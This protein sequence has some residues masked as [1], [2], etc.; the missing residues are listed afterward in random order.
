MLKFGFED[1]GMTTTGSVAGMT[2]TTTNQVA[3]P[4]TLPMARCFSGLLTRKVNDVP[5]V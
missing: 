4:S 5:L 2:L 1:I 3:F